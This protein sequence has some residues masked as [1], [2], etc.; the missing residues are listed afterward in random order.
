[1]L[2]ESNLKLFTIGW[3]AVAAKSRSLV[4]GRQPDSSVVHVRSGRLR[5]KWGMY[6]R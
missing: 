5:S 6:T 1:M 3:Y 2:S 4:N